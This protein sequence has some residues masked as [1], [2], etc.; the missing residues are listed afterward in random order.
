MNP[1]P[2]RWLRDCTRQ[3]YVSMRRTGVCSAVPIENRQIYY[4]VFRGV[5]V[6]FSYRRDI[7]AYPVSLGFESSNVY[8][9]V[10]RIRYPIII[11]IIK[12]RKNNDLFS[13]R[14][15]PPRV[16]ARV[17]AT[18]YAHTMGDKRMR[19]GDKKKKKITDYT[20]GRTYMCV[21]RAFK[22]IHRRSRK[23][24][25]VVYILHTYMHTLPGTNVVLYPDRARLARIAQRS[26]G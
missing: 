13:N 15:P 20:P 7:R 26:T 6:R 5:R 16:R 24:V 21:R 2:S 19:H 12:T 1:S 25:V 4:N 8:T 18:V 14:S 11:I 23:R 3:Y 10:V 17:Q 9:Y 22:K